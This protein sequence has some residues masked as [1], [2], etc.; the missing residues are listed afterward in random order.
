MPASAQLTDDPEHRVSIGKS[1]LGS[2]DVAHDV[3]MSSQFFLSYFCCVPTGWPLISQWLSARDLLSKLSSLH[4]FSGSRYL[5]PSKRLHTPHQLVSFIS[6]HI[7]SRWL[8][9]FPH[10]LLKRSLLQ[11]VL[12]FINLKL[13]DAKI[14]LPLPGNQTPSPLLRSN[15]STQNLNTCS[16]TKRLH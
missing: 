13:I 8:S 16:Y 14:N 4:S 2:V 9:Y 7:C 1:A 11:S 5:F 3:G 12:A 6:R 15:F 10:C